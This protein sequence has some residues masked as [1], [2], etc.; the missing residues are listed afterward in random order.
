M[1][2]LVPDLAKVHK[3]SYYSERF[4]KFLRGEVFQPAKNRPQLNIPQPIKEND[5]A[6]DLPTEK[7]KK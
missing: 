3:P 4:L 2:V 1:L 6:G 5:G 7:V